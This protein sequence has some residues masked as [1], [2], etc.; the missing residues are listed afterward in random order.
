MA[1]LLMRLRGATVMLLAVVLL[2]TLG[3][4]VI[5]N[6]RWSW[7]QSFFHTLITLSTV[8][9]GELPG[10]EHDLV[11][12]SFSLLLVIT[13]A[14][15]VV[16]F[17]SVVTA[18]FVEGE[19]HDHFRKARMRKL[20][21]GMQGHVIV[22]GV[23][24]TGANVVE[25]LT[26]C[27]RPFVAVDGDAA[28]LERL[29]HEFPN[30]RYVVGDA[31]EDAVLRDAGI[32]RAQGLV[33]AL[34]DDQANLYVTLTARSLNPALRII[35]KAV[36]HSAE[37]KLTR[38]GADKVVSTHRIG[39]L[40]L[41]NEMIR[42]HATEFL[43]MMLRDPQHVLRI[44]E[45][46][47][48]EGSAVAGKSLGEAAIGRLAD[49]LVVALRSAEGTYHFNPRDELP[50]HGNCTLIVLCDQAQA[51]RL[52][53]ALRPALAAAPSGAGPRPPTTPGG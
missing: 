34:T 33:A 47:V 1:L 20:I 45:V 13:G 37:P 46:T 17:A 38:A 35:A 10:M 12:R 21:D 28:R 24:R 39:G 48:P 22:C 36:E 2:G 23:G 40:R 31:T 7:F 41:A 15:S 44:E 18:L 5:G 50:L 25:E 43:D 51:T 42:P 49:V 26:V 6:G 29:R 8:G 52:R 3:I 30:L 19:L 32:A 9:Y 53:A 11:A 27:G 14:G 4:R 16:Y